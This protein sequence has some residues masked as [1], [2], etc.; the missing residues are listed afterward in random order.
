MNNELDNFVAVNNKCVFR[1]SKVV[2][3][4]ESIRNDIEESG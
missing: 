1:G 3:A 2:R 4:R